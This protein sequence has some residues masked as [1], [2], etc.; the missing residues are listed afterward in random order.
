ME[1]YHDIR[2]IPEGEE[3]EFYEFRASRK[4]VSPLK[5]KIFLWAVLIGGIVVGTILFLFLFTIFIYVI[6][7]VM[8]LASLWGAFKYWRLRSGK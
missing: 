7:P 4:P 1:E 2:R 5:A 8:I 6:L 3:E